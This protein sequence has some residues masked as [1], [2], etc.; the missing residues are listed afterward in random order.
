VLGSTDSRAVCQ[1]SVTG[2]K[3]KR[4][5][6]RDALSRINIDL[7]IITLIHGP[8]CY[9]QRIAEQGAVFP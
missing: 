5:D 2:Q 1:I 3:H 8:N 7:R 6:K 4:T 9:P